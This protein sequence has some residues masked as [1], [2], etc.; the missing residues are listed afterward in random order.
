MRSMAKR[1]L[2]L[3]ILALCLITITICIPSSLAGVHSSSIQ[4]NKC[5]DVIVDSYCES[6]GVVSI[7]N[8]EGYCM[9]NKVTDEN[10]H[11]KM[12]RDGKINGGNI[13][14]RNADAE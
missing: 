14:A 11:I 10:G 2:N 7:I 8:L 3:A 9:A 12:V 6:S 1:V 13:Y 4:Q 5:G